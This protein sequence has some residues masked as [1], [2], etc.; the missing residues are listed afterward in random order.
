MNGFLLFIDV[1]LSELGNRFLS[2]YNAKINDPGSL[3]C[4]FKS[5]GANVPDLLPVKCS[6]KAIETRKID[7]VPTSCVLTLAE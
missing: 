5:Y 3:S 4:L 6:P 2:L 7:G 1:A